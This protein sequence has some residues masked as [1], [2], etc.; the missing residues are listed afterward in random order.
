MS[1]SEPEEVEKEDEALKLFN[2]INDFQ[3]RIP[4]LEAVAK[5]TPPPRTTYHNCLAHVEKLATLTIKV[6]DLGRF[7]TSSSANPPPPP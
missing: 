4:G 5:A 6:T 3:H 1:E 7:I 2:L